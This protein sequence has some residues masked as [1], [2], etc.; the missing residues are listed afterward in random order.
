MNLINK[1]FNLNTMKD[2]KKVDEKKSTSHSIKEKN[3]KK[4]LETKPLKGEVKTKQEPPVKETEE[5]GIP[6]SK[7]YESEVVELNGR[8]YKKVYNL[9]GTTHFEAIEK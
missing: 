7:P 6:E 5:N 4:S 3:D 8:S 1:L 2:Q 9:D